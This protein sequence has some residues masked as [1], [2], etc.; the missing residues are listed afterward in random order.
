VR[1]AAR[2]AAVVGMEMGEKNIRDGHIDPEAIQPSGQIVVTYVEIESRVDEQVS[3]VA[4]YQITVERPEGIVRKRDFDTKYSVGNLLCVVSVCHCVF[5]VLT[6]APDYRSTLKKALPRF[7]YTNHIIAY[8][9][10]PSECSPDIT[11]FYTFY[12]CAGPALREWMP[13]QVRHD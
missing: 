2:E 3:S 9:K 1:D 7:F 4:R 5:P 10:K 13:D 12:L 6:I 8:H 11:V